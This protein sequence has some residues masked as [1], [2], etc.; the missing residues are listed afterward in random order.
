[1]VLKGQLLRSLKKAMQGEMDSVNIYQHAADDSSDSEVKEFFLSRREEERL[2]YNYLLDYYQQVSSDMQPA[3][4]AGKVKAENLKKSIFSPAF[5]KRIGE[6]QVLFSAISTALLLEK[7]A[8]DHYRTCK[9]ETEI[10]NLKAFFDMMVKWET[11]HYEELAGIQKEAEVFYWE[12][13]DF[14]PF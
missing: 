8:I 2:H 3:D 7:D 14:E 4:I 11:R 6:D 10:T 9:E 12:I 1:M 13:N 5:I